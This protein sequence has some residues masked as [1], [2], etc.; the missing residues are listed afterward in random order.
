IL[1]VGLMVLFYGN[2]KTSE[3]AKVDSTS[4]TRPL[5]SSQNSLIQL[6]ETK[7]PAY[8]SQY[9][10]LD[11]DWEHTTRES[12]LVS[13]VVAVREELLRRNE[14]LSDSD[15]Q[16]VTENQAV[17]E[18]RLNGDTVEDITPL[19][20]LPELRRLFIESKTH[21]GR[22]SELAPLTDVPLTALHMSRTSVSELSPLRGMPLESLDI[23]HTRVYSLA[24]LKGL[25]LKRLW[26]NKTEITELRPLEDMPLTVLCFEQT[27]VKDVDILA[28]FPLRELRMGPW[29][30]PPK[31]LG[32]LPL[33]DLTVHDWNEPLESG[34]ESKSSI[35]T[36]NNE[37]AEAFWK[38]HKRRLAS[39]NVQP[40][41]SRDVDEFL[42]APLLIDVRGQV[43]SSTRH[44]FLSFDPEANKKDRSH[45]KDVK[46][47]IDSLGYLHKE[48]CLILPWN[49]RRL[50]V[51]SLRDPEANV[52]YIS[53]PFDPKLVAVHGP[54]GL[55]AVTRNHD[56]YN[57][58]EIVLLDFKSGKVHHTLRRTGPPI[59]ALAFNASG[60]RLVFTQAYQ[61][62]ALYDVAQNRV[63]IEQKTAGECFKT[64]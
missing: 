55:V 28:K 13:Q 1:L 62:V 64:V 14:R 35:A 51:Q 53:L 56:N 9:R 47:A 54:S 17:V 22:F 37:P 61:S 60:T 48:D 27:K 15:I 34:L 3:I 39:P 25:M 29:Q 57:N 43:W 32:Q 26:M 12:A 38:W 50:R 7:R 52:R 36:I 18:V 2:R 63:L 58:R 20:A 31:T 45:T 49:N 21:G 33:V 44:K 41:S 40:R 5:A 30:S 6:V 42:Q 16:F 24:A 19:R 10:Y 4:R 8:R 46:F 23:S 59:T 11:A